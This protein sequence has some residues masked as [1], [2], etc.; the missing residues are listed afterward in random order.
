[1]SEDSEE[2]IDA[3]P[4]D[5]PEPTDFVPGS[6]EKIEVL[7]KRFWSGQQLWNDGDKITGS[8]KC[9]DLE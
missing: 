7:R 5:K 4:V 2:T 1:M 9:S 8:D 6:K 3:E